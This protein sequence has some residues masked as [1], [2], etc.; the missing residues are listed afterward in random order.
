M[1]VVLDMPVH[2]RDGAPEARRVHRFHDLEPLPVLILSGQITARTSSSRISAA[3]PGSELGPAAFSSC[4]KS[5]RFRPVVL[6]PCQISSGEKAW[7]CMP[8]TAS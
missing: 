1:L 4:R 2:D 3:V 5:G 7:I 8:G 6:A